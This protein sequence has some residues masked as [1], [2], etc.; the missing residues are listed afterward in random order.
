LNGTLSWR[1]Q[2][3]E[4]FREGNRGRPFHCYGHLG[5]SGP[6]AVTGGSF[7]KQ[8]KATSQGLIIEQSIKLIALNLVPKNEKTIN[9]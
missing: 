6:G 7:P 2:G 8:E 5:R 9:F 4:N 3:T 1:G